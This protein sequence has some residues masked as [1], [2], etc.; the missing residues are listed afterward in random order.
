MADKVHITKSGIQ[1]LKWDS[2]VRQYVEQRIRSGV[3]VLRCAC[4]IDAGVTLGDI[5]RAVEQDRA[6]L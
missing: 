1:A 3:H 4:Y 5:F 2:D 6:M